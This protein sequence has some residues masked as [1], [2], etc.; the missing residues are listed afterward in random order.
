MGDDD[1]SNVSNR[2][3]RIERRLDDLD[4]KM[5]ARPPSSF[6]DSTIRFIIY[7]LVV[8]IVALGTGTA[9]NL[10]GLLK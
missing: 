7:G 2:L 10:S 8:A 4:K 6:A 5:E 9:V 1:G 3:W